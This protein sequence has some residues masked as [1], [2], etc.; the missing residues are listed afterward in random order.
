MIVSKHHTPADV[1]RILFQETPEL[2]TQPRE[3]FNI[4]GKAFLRIRE[5]KDIG[6]VFGQTIEDSLPHHETEDIDDIKY[7]LL[8][9][10]S[11]SRRQALRS[12]LEGSG[13]AEAFEK[14]SLIAGGSGIMPLF[15][16]PP[17]AGTKNI[18]QE[19]LQDLNTEDDDTPRKDDAAQ[20]R[21]QAEDEV[22]SVQDSG[23]T[24]V[25]KM[26]N[27]AAVKKKSRL[28]LM[29]RGRASGIG[30]SGLEQYYNSSS[31]SP[32]VLLVGNS[33]ASSSTSPVMNKKMMVKTSARS[34]VSSAGATSTRRP[35]A[36]S[37]SD[38][39][40]Y[41]GTKF[42]YF[43]EKRRASGTTTGPR[44][45]RKSGTTTTPV[46][47]TKN[48]RNS[49]RSS[50]VTGMNRPNGRGAPKA[51]AQR[52]LTLAEKQR[53]L[54]REEAVR[55]KMMGTMLG[56]LRG[57]ELLGNADNPALRYDVDQDN[58]V[59]DRTGP[60]GST[61]PP[62]NNNNK[63][64]TQRQRRTITREEK[65]EQLRQSNLVKNT[66]KFSDGLA[67][68][69]LE[70]NTSYNREVDVGAAA[71]RSRSQAFTT[72]SKGPAN[73]LKSQLAKHIHVASLPDFKVY[74]CHECVMKHDD[75][76]LRNVLERAFHQGK[77]DL[78]TDA[79]CNQD[80]I[81]C[82]KLLNTKAVVDS[83]FPS[84]LKDCLTSADAFN[85]WI[86]QNRNKASSSHTGN[87][88]G[89]DVYTASAFLQHHRKSARLGDKLLGGWRHREDTLQLTTATGNDG[90]PVSVVMSTHDREFSTGHGNNPNNTAGAMHATGAARSNVTTRYHP[91]LSVQRS[92]AEAYDMAKAV[93]ANDE[94][95]FGEGENERGVFD[96]QQGQGAVVLGAR[97]A[98]AGGDASG[99]THQQAERV[100]L[101][102]LNPQ[103]WVSRAPDFLVEIL[104]KDKKL[105]QG[106]YLPNVTHLKTA[107]RT[108]EE[109]HMCNFRV[110]E[111]T[112]NEVELLCSA[113]MF[114]RASTLLTD[115]LTYEKQGLLR[116]EAT[117]IR[118][119]FLRI[120]LAEPHA[121]TIEPPF[122]V[123]VSMRPAFGGEVVPVYASGP[124]AVTHSKLMTNRLLG[125][126]G[127]AAVAVDIFIPKVEDVPS[128]PEADPFLAR[129]A[130]LRSKMLFENDTRA[131]PGSKSLSMGRVFEYGGDLK[132]F[133]CLRDLE[134]WFHLIQW[135]K[136][137]AATEA[138]A[139]PYL[140]PIH[141]P[142]FRSDED[143]VVSPEVVSLLR[144]DVAWQ[145][146]YS[147]CVEMVVGAWGYDL[148]QNRTTWRVDHSSNRAN[149][150]DKVL[151][152]REL[153]GF[154][155]GGSGR[156]QY[157][158]DSWKLRH[159]LL[160]L[161]TFKI[162]KLYEIVSE[163]G[164]D[165]LRDGVLLNLKDQGLEE[166]L[167][168]NK[169]D[170][171]VARVW[172]ESKLWEDYHKKWIPSLE[173]L[174]FV[175]LGK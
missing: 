86:R 171:H 167:H 106:K 27:S 63:N 118:L 68:T 78:Q 95:Y 40:H 74:F 91:H 115:G 72:S 66:N 60:P 25:D 147:R 122:T 53:Q 145:E 170:I 41:Q 112:V 83:V 144:D 98:A 61:S 121:A 56:G 114:D 13:L 19:H 134:A 36:G 136:I 127:H 51:K 29:K 156:H 172:L 132:E 99:P 153:R 133:P 93:L 35:L 152:S 109:V 113:Q 149:V 48:T 55:V 49:A 128:A 26:I 140:F 50:Q 77:I 20:G 94:P 173:E 76:K 137:R 38:A 65:E 9:L 124:I 12:Q 44:A 142:T 45:S 107:G 129:A 33:P 3:F 81:Q 23:A 79:A 100:Y 102:N 101:L 42:L 84:E 150:D 32:G 80:C 148:L 30:V 62:G 18:E 64:T 11:R 59:S 105:G 75:A 175:P 111:K 4:T 69:S 87:L 166:A 24:Q 34:S 151:N 163:I 97:T 71:A 2:R 117:C 10:S 162:G 85:E 110:A 90:Q 14:A 123:R 154:H 7:R 43:P 143:F 159:L 58:E 17:V 1:R 82:R 96:Q 169:K 158:P 131:K 165:L 139:M 15:S 73:Q 39:G 155:P 89:P 103:T 28:S 92:A 161:R 54:A 22:D 138:N 174:L 5:E 8:L 125:H 108:P 116:K 52:P 21:Q 157:S 88:L 16:S 135:H 141:L 46:A 104:A 126:E 57:A 31:S 119:I 146:A 168:A 70:F 6:F 67:G 37:T 160:S 47:A 130:T 120:T 164:Q